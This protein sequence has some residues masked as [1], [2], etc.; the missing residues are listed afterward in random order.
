VLAAH[1]S[2][3]YARPLLQNVSAEQPRRSL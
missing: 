1:G 3:H 2:P